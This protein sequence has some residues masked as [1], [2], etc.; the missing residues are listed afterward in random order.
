M[1][2][3]YLKSSLDKILISGYVEKN[4]SN[5]FFRPMK[6]WVYIVINNQIIELF[7]ADGDIKINEI[8]RI[9]CPFE[10]EEDDIFVLTNY[11]EDSLN[12]D[13][14]IIENIEYSY[15]AAN[16]LI[17]IFI[18]TSTKLIEFNALCIDGF[19]ISVRN[20]NNNNTINIKN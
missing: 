20:Y 2:E 4:D 1:L 16:N 15:D 11:A 6:W 7:A 17:K 14:G 8:E 10:I 13:F 19:D 9:N 3:R 5:Y 18:E 12:D